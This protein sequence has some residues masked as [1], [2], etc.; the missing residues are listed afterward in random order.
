MRDR[1]TYHPDGEHIIY[2]DDM[3]HEV[4]SDFAHVKKAIAGNEVDDYCFFNTYGYMYVDV[5]TWDKTG[6]Y[7]YYANPYGVMEIGKWFQF[8]DTVQWANGVSAAN[9]AEKY[10]YATE[11]GTLL[12]ST[13]TYNWNNQ[14]V[15]LQANGTVATGILYDGMNY[16]V[17]DEQEGYI[18]NVIPGNNL[19]PDPSAPTARYSY[20]LNTLNQYDLYSDVYVVLALR[21]DNPESAKIRLRYSGRDLGGVVGP[22]YNDVKYLDE[23]LLTNDWQEIKSQTGY[24]KTILFREP[25]IKDIIIEEETDQ[26]WTEVERLILNVKDKAAGE[27]AW[28]K[29]V[30]ESEINQSGYDGL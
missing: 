18:I 10:G 28:Y 26:G 22:R 12:T 2:F 13:W 30:I 4:F 1:L 5:L 23:Y 7:L 15:Y 29:S 25:G 24:I 11:N 6:Q 19:N 16:Y 3:G 14:S 21:T 27:D 20:S 8:S 9:I 17:L